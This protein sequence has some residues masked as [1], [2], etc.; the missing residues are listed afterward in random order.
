MVILQ[1]WYQGRLR[2][3]RRKDPAWQSVGFSPVLRWI[4]NPASAT[5]LRSLNMAR[6]QINIK[7]G[8]FVMDRSFFRIITSICLLLKLVSNECDLRNGSDLTGLEW[9][10]KS[11]HEDQV[12]TICLKPQNYSFDLPTFKVQSSCG[13][14]WYLLYQL[15]PCSSII[16]HNKILASAYLLFY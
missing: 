13:M 12:K 3:R 5:W 15:L 4:E 14:K 2:L 10:N 1:T 7:T 8:C 11:Q 9:I 6:Y 16:K